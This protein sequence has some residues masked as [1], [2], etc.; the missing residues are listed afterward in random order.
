MLLSFL[1]FFIVY[2]IYD[3][4]KLIKEKEWKIISIYYILIIFATILLFFYS[5]NGAVP[6]PSDIIEEILSKII[7]VKN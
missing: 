3:S 1:V 7:K 2:T 4:I 5:F 6:N